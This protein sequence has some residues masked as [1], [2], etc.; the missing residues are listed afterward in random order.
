VTGLLDSVLAILVAIALNVIVVQQIHS[1]SPASE[2][3][4]LVK[5][6]MATLLL[7]S[8]LAILL[9]IFASDS[10]V[11]AAFWGDSETYDAAG[12]QLVLR[13]SGEPQINILMST[14]VSGYGW[15]YYVGSLYYVFGRNQ[16]LVQ[17]LNCL[18]GGVT[19]LVIYAIA[20]HLFDHKTARW[21]ALFM[22]FFPQM[23]FWST[24][25]YKD[26]PILLCIAVAM[27]AVVRLRA[28]FSLPIVGLF[29]V[30]VV[31]LITLRFYVAYFVLMAAAGTFVFGQ[32][33]S[34][35]RTLIT[36]SLMAG[37]LFGAL[38]F[39]VKRETLEQQTTYVSL[40]RLQ[41]TLDT[42]GRARRTADRTRLF[43]F[44][45]FSLGHFGL[46]PGARAARDPGV[47]RLDACLRERAGGGAAAAV[48]RRTADPCLCGEPDVG[49][50]TDAGQRGDSVSSAHASHHV[51]LHLHGS[52]PRGEAPP[53]ALLC[54]TRAPS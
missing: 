53:P 11:A 27:Y 15:V 14:A 16:L 36:Y 25:M 2:T 22:A 4:F 28:S 43:A 38:N 54:G 29:V 21:A 20:A 34:A 9:N 51:L 19:T 42:R 24:G 18:I 48:S 33:G 47:V 37:L 23:V 12:H 49:L 35:T 52:W 45:S 3:S 31:A 1:R 8:G 13:W 44:R 40:E 46:P 32:R 17:L 5:V 30:S 41:V 26:P 7:R 39:A 10:A 50:R 6:Y